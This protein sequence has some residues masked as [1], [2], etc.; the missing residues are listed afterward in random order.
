MT[1]RN[2]DE[3]RTGTAAARGLDHATL[4]AANPELI[5]CAVTPFGLTGPWSAT[6]GGDPLANF[7]HQGEPVRLPGSSAVFPVNGVYT[8]M[9][10]DGKTTESYQYNVAYQRQVFTRILLDVTYTGNQ[11]R[12]IW[13]AG[14]GENPAIYI[15]GNCAPGQYP[16]SPRQ[17]PPARTR[18]RPT[19]RL[20]RC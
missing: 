2:F 6:A 19:A 15:P 20:V 8:S 12:H 5:T 3:L 16:G 14:Y 10:V 9:P 1:R 11:Q 18:R 4:A 7:A 17:L 13:A